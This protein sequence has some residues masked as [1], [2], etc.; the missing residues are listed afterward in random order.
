MFNL[1]LFNKHIYN[2][3]SGVAYRF[4][5]ILEAEYFEE[6]PQVNRAFIVGVDLTGGNVT[7]NAITSAEASLVGE[8]LDVRHDTNVTSAAAAA[9]AASAVLDKARLDGRKAKITVPLHCGL[10]LWDVVSIVD[11]PANQATFYRVS[12][13]TL[14][15]DTRQNRYAQ[16]LELAAV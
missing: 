4:H 10:E 12:G 14:E 7:G 13:Y 6:S 5:S 11:V 15:I 9:Y 3:S 2:R 16:Y 8:R 1:F